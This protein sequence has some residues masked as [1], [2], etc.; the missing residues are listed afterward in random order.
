MSVPNT[1]FFFSFY[2]AQNQNLMLND[3]ELVLIVAVLTSF[4]TV[5]N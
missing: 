1:D 2:I 3:F 5:R 4:V